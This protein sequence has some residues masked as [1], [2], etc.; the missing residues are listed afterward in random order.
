MK[1]KNKIFLSFLIVSIIGGAVVF[2]LV[3]YSSKEVTTK[4][5]G[6]Y[7][8][9]LAEANIDSLDRLVDRRIEN[10]SLYLKDNNDLISF[11]KALN[12][13]FDSMKDRDIFLAKN[14]EIVVEMK[15]KDT[16]PIVES[17]I[18]NSI[19][20]DI[21]KN[22]AFFNERYNYEIFPELFITNKY[23]AVVA[24]NHKISGYDQSKDTWWINARDN[25]VFVEDMSYDESSGFNSLA[26]C[27]RINDENGNFLGVSRVIYN[28]EDIFSLLRDIV[29]NSNDQTINNLFITRKTTNVLLLNRENKLLYSSKGDIIFSDYSILSKNIGID[30]S[31]INYYV[32]NYNGTEK[33]FSFAKS[34]GYEN[35]RG[36]GWKLIISKETN[37]ALAPFQNQINTILVFILTATI[38]MAFILFRILKVMLKSI[39]NL[40]LGIKKIESG[41]FNFKVDTTDKDE[42]GMLSR[43]FNTMID[44]VVK[45]R[46][47]VD[48]KVFE[49]TKEIIDKEKK[50][51]SQKDAILN[52]M[53]DITKEKEMS[54]KLANDLEK[55]KLA[56][57]N[58]SD[59]VVIT[60]NEGI[61][62]YG[63]MAVEK[64]T[65]YKPEE[66]LGKKAGVLWKTPMPKEYYE[67]LWNTIKNQKKTFIS[68]IQN[69][70][71]SG[72]LYIANL[73]ISPV[74][75][76]KNNIIYFVSIEHDISKEKEIDKAKTE[77]VSLASHQLRTPLSA[78]NWYTEMLL[79]GDA[80][81]INEE[82]KKYL[83][84]VAN[85]N[86]RMVELVG[87]LLN[88]SRLDLGTFI[89]EPELIDVSEISKS[90]LSELKP[91]ILDKNLKVEE[92][93]G[94]NISQFKA[95][96][97]LLRIVFQN[98][99]SNAVK[100]TL[101]DGIIKINISVLVKE[102]IFGQK[103]FNEEKLAIS[104]SDSGM[105]IPKNQQEKVFTKLFRADNAR[106]SE[107]EG[108]G[109]GLYI[110]KSIVDQS[111][112]EIWFSS[113]ENKGTKFYVV[114]P[115]TGMKKKEGTKKLD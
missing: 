10:W 78:I 34:A 88:V 28:I 94:E 81:T 73:S 42:I 17:L 72:E 12:S 98:L 68:E 37:E 95:D 83:N 76:E 106:E 13:K 9:F 30:D 92:F 50:L 66:V 44:S 39:N 113:E 102:E 108:T 56:V 47:E 89:I 8:A 84:E 91:Q 69:K 86:K 4:T 16:N 20:K 2:F 62:I 7:N 14:E 71:K 67:N 79:A 104:I 96:K 22:L 57:D 15:E 53:D 105:G 59:Q 82:Q 46:E 52:V 25:G 97:K 43:S 33:M 5:V 49:Q 70:R 61:V 36:L 115:I 24:Q 100:Y 90:V 55:F 109:L 6:S 110:I 18:N 65:G 75:D 60:D 107:T 64:I 58:A 85:G 112:G 41:D 19:S 93:Y 54:E 63:N 21:R 80:G 38:I 45:S 27:I 11:L 48:K 99:L 1:I 111:G 23:G 32:Y 114:F 3:R 51:E 103:G 29:K 87:A 101:K 31:I 74:L 40:L 77:F 26:I 35:Y